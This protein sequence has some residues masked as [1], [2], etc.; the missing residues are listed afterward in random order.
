MDI[1][2]YAPPGP[3]P[4]RSLAGSRG[5]QLT[6]N[7]FHRNSNPT[8]FTDV[9]DVHVCAFIRRCPLSILLKR[10]TPSSLFARLLRVVFGGAR[11]RI[12]LC[13]ER[14]SPPGR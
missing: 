5:S 4:Y 2:Y 10:T 11:T 1:I 8:L 14:G 9:Q 3:V 12:G 6:D 13:F 7:R